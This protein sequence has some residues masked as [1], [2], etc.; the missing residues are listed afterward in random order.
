MWNLKAWDDM[1]VRSL[2]PDTNN[3]SRVVVTTRNANVAN[4]LG[5]YCVAMGFL[6]EENS[7]HLFCQNAFAEQQGCCPLELEKTAKMI[8][9]RCKGLPLAIVVVGGILKKS[10]MTL[11]YWENVAQ[12]I[13]HS[14]DSNEQCLNV[15]SLSYRYLPADRKPCFLLLGS[16]PEDEQINAPDVIKLWIAEGFIQHFH[17]TRLEDDAAYF[18][19]DLH[20]RN[21]ILTEQLDYKGNIITFKVHDLVREL[22]LQ[23]AKK[24]DFLSVFETSRGITRERRVLINGVV[25]HETITTDA[26][27]RCLICNGGRY[28]LNNL[29]DLKML[30][31]VSNVFTTF[32]S[33]SIF[34]QVNLRYLNVNLVYIPRRFL[35]YLP[36]SIS[37]LWNLQILTI[38]LP[39][40]SKVIAPYEIWEM[41]QLRQIEVDMICLVDPLPVDNANHMAMRSLYTLS[42]VE[43]FRLSE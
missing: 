15:L 3:G 19:W 39:N 41:L 28:G 9:A 34:Q 31:T 13:L 7:W 42:K 11:V 40:Q 33:E 18:L 1:N 16:F 30:R 14:T 5:D 43:N 29:N 20:M 25:N 17:D 35:Y 12:S 10:P 21:L 22:C 4:H 38:I 2:F 37:L 24:E 32:I 26:P 36:S 8:V 27:V 6:D 23:I